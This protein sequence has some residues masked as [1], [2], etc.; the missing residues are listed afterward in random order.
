MVTISSSG[1]T[2]SQPSKLGEG[3]SGGL[4]R[5]RLVSLQYAIA[6][7][8]ASSLSRAVPSSTAAQILSGF[9]DR[10]FLRQRCPPGRSSGAL[11]APARCSFLANL[12][13]HRLTAWPFGVAVSPPS[14]TSER[15]LFDELLRAP[16]KEED[17]DDL[18]DGEEPGSEATLTLSGLNA[19]DDERLCSTR[20]VE[21]PSAVAAVATA[22][23]IV[24]HTAHG[25]IHATTTW[26]K[27]M[28]IRLRSAS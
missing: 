2:R 15:A 9:V 12:R 6:L 24:A 16:S 27:C 18:D 17:V 4:Q 5:C 13:R 1:R 8:T 21:A 20:T 10:L 23:A 19:G 26:K 22:G 11:S 7:A 3:A 28:V 25:N 14:L